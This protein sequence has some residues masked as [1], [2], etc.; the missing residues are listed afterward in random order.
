MLPDEFRANPRLAVAGLVASRAKLQA[1][2]RD[3]FADD[4]W[5]AAFWR[6]AKKN[7]LEAG[8]TRA[9]LRLSKSSQIANPKS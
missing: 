6:D 1:A 9:Q 7:R 8:A 3:N 4:R 2:L 5:P